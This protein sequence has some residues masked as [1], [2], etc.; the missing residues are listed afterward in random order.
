LGRRTP[1]ERVKID[2]VLDEV[3]LVLVLVPFEARPA[4]GQISAYGRKGRYDTRGLKE[5]KGGEH[6]EHVGAALA[7]YEQDRAEAQAFRRLFKRFIL[8]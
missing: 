5:V 2:T 8:M 7:R 4:Y 6:A 1:T 3:A